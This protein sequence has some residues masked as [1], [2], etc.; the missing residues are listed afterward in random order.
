[1]L[2]HFVLISKFNDLFW[3]DLHVSSTAGKRF[4]SAPLYIC[5]LLFSS[6]VLLFVW[7]PHSAWDFLCLHCVTIYSSLQL[8]CQDAL[9]DPCGFLFRD[10][11]E[12]LMTDLQV[13]SEEF[14]YGR[15]KIFIRNPR[16][17]NTISKSH[18]AFFSRSVRHLLRAVMDQAVPERRV[19]SAALFSHSTTGW[20]ILRAPT[21]AISMQPLLAE[22][23][24]FH[25]SIPS[26]MGNELLYS[27]LKGSLTLEACSI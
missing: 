15:S 20:A 1:M 8:F 7:V 3:R 2:R 23:T 13:P 5:V 9:I 11:V 14:S 6:L 10:G 21:S 4:I 19:C 27:A 12:V 16:T 26:Y 17:V 25:L 22:N 18:K 24:W